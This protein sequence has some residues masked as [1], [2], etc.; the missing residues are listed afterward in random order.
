MSPPGIAAMGKPTCKTQLGRWMSLAKTMLGR[1]SPHMNRGTAA[2]A[3]SACKGGATAMQMGWGCDPI[4]CH[5][6]DAT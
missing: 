4:T 3:K 1:G 2:I 5:V 6:H